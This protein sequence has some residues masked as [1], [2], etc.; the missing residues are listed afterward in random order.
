MNSILTNTPQTKGITNLVKTNIPHYKD[1][2]YLT[3]HD[4]FLQIYAITKQQFEEKTIHAF[5]YFCYRY[6]ESLQYLQLPEVPSVSKYEAVLIEFRCFPHLEFLI[7]NAIHK[8]GK[9]WSHTIVCGNTNHAMVSAIC[10]RISP[11]IRILKLPYENID[12]NVYNSDICLNIE[13]WKQLQGQKILL[14]QEDTMI[15][16]NTIASFLNYDYIGAPWKISN[17]EIS[18][19][20]VGNGGLS[21]RSKHTMI[22][23]LEKIPDKKI[24]KDRV[25]KH[26]SGTTLDLPPED[27]F[28]TYVMK[29]HT[30]GNL[31]KK[32]VAELF[33][34]ELIQNRL[35]FGGHAFFLFDAKWKRRMY[36][37]IDNS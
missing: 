13:F 24:F 4:E 29:K 10:S 18:D 7:R 25:F 6:I 33:S 5:R 19:H 1:Q 9:E 11:N 32:D 21:L 28:F 12:I 17:T 2:S 30:I 15:F 16:R 27:V 34:S 35:S 14:Y 22:E 26:S 37:H 23:I 20:L 31:A 36:K 8:L 3:K